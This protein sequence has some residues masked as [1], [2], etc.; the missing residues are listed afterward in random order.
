M[1][2]AVGGV[3]QVNLY[4]LMSPTLCVIVGHNIHLVYEHS[5][6]N[7]LRFLI[8]DNGANKHEPV[9]VSAMR[10]ARTWPISCTCICDLD[11]TY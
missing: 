7:Q 11:F 10:D 8:G 3:E 6:N 9:R 4:S 2:V 1:E 5:I